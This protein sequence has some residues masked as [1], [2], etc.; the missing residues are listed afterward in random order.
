MF[1]KLKVNNCF[2]F[3]LTIILLASAVGYSSGFLWNIPILRN[4]RLNRATEEFY[5]FH[6]TVRINCKPYFLT[7]TGL[8]NFHTCLESCSWA[9]QHYISDNELLYELPEGV[10]VYAHWHHL[11]GN[12]DIDPILDFILVSQISSKTPYHPSL[13]F[14]D[15]QF[16]LGFTYLPIRTKGILSQYQPDGEGV[17]VE[18]HVFF[19]DLGKLSYYPPNASM[20]SKAV[21]AISVVNGKITTLSIASDHSSKTYPVNWEPL[22]EYEGTLQIDE[23]VLHIQQV[24]SFFESK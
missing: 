17:N 11:N 22:V 14:L 16:N 20:R 15:E 6:D 8:L 13:S 9:I 23:F 24:R 19:P 1:R 10:I 7:T 3:F 18:T 4:F 5:S 12:A 21:A 2:L